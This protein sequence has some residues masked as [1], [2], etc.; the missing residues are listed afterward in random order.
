MR[1][2]VEDIKDKVLVDVV[3]HFSESDMMKLTVWDRQTNSLRF[4]TPS[5]VVKDSSS[6][7]LPCMFSNVTIWIAPG[8]KLD[9][10]LIQTESFS[11]TVH[12]G[13]SFDTKVLKI[14]T[15]AGSVTFPNRYPTGSL[16]NYREVIISTVS[17]SI[18][19]DFPLYDLLSIT[20][21]SGTV[22]IGLEPKE[23]AEHASVPAQLHVET[24]SGTI[25]VNT[26][27]VVGA[28]ESFIGA[29]IPDRDY[30]VFVSSTSGTQYVNVIHGSETILHSVSGTVQATLSPYGA[31]WAK[32]NIDVVTKSGSVEVT[33]LSSISHAGQAMTN[34]YGTYKRLSGSLKVKYPGEWEGEIE[35]STL[36]GSLNIAWPGLT[37][38]QD[39]RSGGSGYRIL[40][41]IKGHGHGQLYFE[42]ISG[43]TDLIGGA[44]R[45]GRDTWDGS[46]E[47]GWGEGWED[48]G[49]PPIVGP[50][51]EPLVEIPDLGGR[52]PSRW[53]GYDD[54]W[55]YE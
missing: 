15:V 53:P 19:G 52:L 50:P 26:P 8:A 17:G 34:L 20:S 37:V 21:I 12:E 28:G 47:G 27:A 49:T 33:V 1:P 42:G 9:A 35:G 55:I 36:S 10:L 48:I 22:N 32:S 40:K 38:I 23:A 3:T 24:V 45:G 41:A 44:L 25:Y 46:D 13:L 18:H 29:A 14:S 54:E 11:V 30:R 7:S 16:Y 6:S 39:G 31:P 4:Y 43:S 51:D 5:H 2:M